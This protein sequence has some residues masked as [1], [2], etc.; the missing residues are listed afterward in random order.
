MTWR[1]DI[2]DCVIETAAGDRFVFEFRDLRT[3]RTERTEQ[4]AFRTDGD[5]VQRTSSGSQHISVTLWFSGP[6]CHASA[7]AFELAT[8]DPRPLRF[9]HPL[10][11]K[12]YLMQLLSIE[13]SDALATAAGEVQFELDLHETI[14]LEK[15][16]KPENVKRFIDN[17]ITTVKLIS[18]DKYGQAIS[19][20][21]PG[22][23][24]K[25]KAALNS[26]MEK[27]A[28]LVEAYDRVTSVV[29]QVQS[30]IL[31]AQSMIET[32]ETTASAFADVAF[33]ALRTIQNSILYVTDKVD[34]YRELLSDLEHGEGALEDPA[35]FKLLNNAV[36]AEWCATAAATTE[37][38]YTTKSDVFALADEIQEFAA[39]VTAE[40]DV[41]EQEDI[42]EQSESLEPDTQTPTLIA[43]IV[44]RTCGRLA[45]IAYRAKQERTYTLARDEEMYSLVY[46]L[47]GGDTPAALD[48][49]I[50]RFIAANEIGGSELFEIKKGRVVKYYV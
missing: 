42:E 19:K 35:T 3:K 1:D 4:F 13:R 33:G 11:K 50:D 21:T 39:G 8:R 27:M 28:V 49:N 38:D 37:D 12:P 34:F 18:A 14:E 48:T 26:V 32:L 29:A 9:F 22:E 7:D 40:L 41:I 47:M 25:I 20:K 24:A 46:R 31:T 45:E 30:V 2:A 5:Y 36:T 44:A 43:D 23:I 17:T 6:L 10:R 16:V 15:Q